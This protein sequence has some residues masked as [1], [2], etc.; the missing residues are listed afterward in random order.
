[1]RVLGARLS[2]YK[3]SAGSV[4]VG[5]GPLLTVRPLWSSMRRRRSFI[6]PS[7][8]GPKYTSHR[9]S[10]TSSS[11]TYSPAGVCDA[12]PPLLPANAAVA[13][14]EADFEV[15]GVVEGRESPRQ[16]AFRPS[17]V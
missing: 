10:P 7:L 5:D 8:S 9:P 3:A 12:D 1:M 13:T 14:D 2:S 6:R 16:L 17:I 15:P 11:P 4:V